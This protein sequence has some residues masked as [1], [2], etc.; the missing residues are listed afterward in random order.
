M[1]QGKRKKREEE[2]R[3]GFGSSVHVLAWTRPA[4]LDNLGG[5]ISGGMRTPRGDSDGNIVY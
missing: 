4:Y 1:K 2:K 5:N 3:N